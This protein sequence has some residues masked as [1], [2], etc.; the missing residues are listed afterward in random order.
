[1]PVFQINRAE[2]YPAIFA[3]QLERC[4]VSYFDYYLLH[5]IGKTVLPA[6]ER[7]DGFGFLR[8]MKA[9]GKIRHI[10]FSYHDDAETLDRILRDHPETELVQLQINYIDWE[11]A[12]I[13][14]RR[15][16]EV[17]LRHGVEVSVMEPLKGGALAIPPERANRIL[18][19]ANPAASAASWA[20]R[21]AASLDNVKVVLSGMGSMEQIEDNLRNMDPLKPLT[22]LE[23]EVIQSV[24][25]SINDSIAI[26]CTACRYCTDGCPQNIAIPEYFALYN[27]Q[28]Q[29]ALLPGIQ[30]TFDN[31]TRGGGAPSDCIACGQCE[32]HCPQHLPIVELLKQVAERF[33]V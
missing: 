7:M 11:N 9:E 19:Q 17:C 2:Q 16:Y 20:L 12:S 8:R 10:G 21:F 27:N 15:C 32:R 14:S 13:Q 33:T 5:A 30:T 3:E 28:K 24:V 29:F 23:R 1:M 25:A 4:G 22:K 6:I 18:R 31:L 26:P